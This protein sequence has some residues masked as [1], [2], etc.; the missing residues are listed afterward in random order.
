MARHRLTTWATDP[1][2]LTILQKTEPEWTWFLTA[3]FGKHP[4]GTGSP[5][6]PP[7]R[8][9]DAGAKF[10]RWC[11]EWS[12]FQGGRT[13]RAFRLLLW[14]AESH[15][16]GDVHIHALSVCT[17]LVYATH[18][19]RCNP[20]VAYCTHEYQQLKE[21]H[22]IHHGKMVA[23]RYNPALKFGA[24]Q[25]VTKYILKESCL[26]WGLEEW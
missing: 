2:R 25:Y 3:T 6:I 20:R 17:P 22:W 10:V 18:C 14:A 7:H 5:A 1:R 12:T 21:S 8:A 13:I 23:R 4:D 11:S 24:E 26:D 15:L 9:M 19:K 16:T